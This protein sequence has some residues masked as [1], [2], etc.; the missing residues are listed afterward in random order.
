MAVL[1]LEFTRF[2]L[3]M[4]DNLLHFTVEDTDQMPV[5]P[6]PHLSVCIF[7]RNRIIGLLNFNVTVR[8]LSVSVRDRNFRGWYFVRR[9]EYAIMETTHEAPIKIKSTGSAGPWPGAL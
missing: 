4:N 3:N 9:Q 5:P 1:C 6:C 8:V 2:D 7:R